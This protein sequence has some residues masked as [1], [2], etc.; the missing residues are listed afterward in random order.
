MAIW[1]GVTLQDESKHKFFFISNLAQ[2]SH[3][4]EL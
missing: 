4:Y 2:M 3:I 1:N